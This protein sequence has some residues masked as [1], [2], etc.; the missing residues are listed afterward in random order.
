MDFSPC[1]GQ[2]TVGFSVVVKQIINYSW[3]HGGVKPS[4]WSIEGDAAELQEMEE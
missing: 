2:Q 1:L 4:H 3:K